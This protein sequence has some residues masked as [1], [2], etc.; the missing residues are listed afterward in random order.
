LDGGI[1]GG[2]AEWHGSEPSVSLAAPSVSLLGLDDE[3]P[4]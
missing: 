2:L 4:S 1:A 3:D